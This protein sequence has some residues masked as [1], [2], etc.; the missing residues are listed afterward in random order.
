MTSTSTNRNEQIRLRITKQE[1]ERWQIFAKRKNIDL[2][3]LIH[4]AVNR[5]IENPSS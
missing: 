5:E 3:K 4:R 1:K 2:S